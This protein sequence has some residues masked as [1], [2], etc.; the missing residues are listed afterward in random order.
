MKNELFLSKAFV[1]CFSQTQKLEN[2][3]KLTKQLE[4]IRRQ[5]EQLSKLKKAWRAAH[6]ISQLVHDTDVVINKH[7]RWIDLK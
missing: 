3:L 2:K 6:G 5:K 4:E 7:I 1:N